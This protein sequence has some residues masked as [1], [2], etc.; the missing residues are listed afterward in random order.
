MRYVPTAN[1]ALD[2][3]KAKGGLK[4]EIV[5]G[6]SINNSLYPVKIRVT[7][8]RDSRFYQLN[9]DYYCTK[10]EFETFLTSKK[11]EVIEARRIAQKKLEEALKILDEIR[12]YFTF[13]EFK[14]IYESSTKSAKDVYSVFEEYIQQKKDDQ[15]FGTANSYTDALKALKKHKKKLYFRDITPSFLKKF[16]QSFENKNTVGIYLRPLRAVYNYAIFKR[17][18]NRDDYPFNKHSYTIPK[19]SS[20]DLAMSID[21]LKPLFQ[22][23]QKHFEEKAD[24]KLFALDMF[25][26][27]YFCGGMNFAD[28]ARLKHSD[29]INNEYFMFFRNK[30]KG[31]TSNSIPTIA[32][33]N[34]VSKAII[35]KHANPFALK[36]DY[37]FPIIQKGISE[38]IIVK[39]IN[40]KRSR[41]NKKLKVIADELNLKGFSTYS[42]RHSFATNMRNENYSYDDIGDMMSHANTTIT[43]GYV[44]K[45]KLDKCKRASEDILRSLQ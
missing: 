7:F 12:D 27:S 36:D 3:R 15:K 30:S 9:K 31:R 11:G 39:R 37:I 43:K 6:E 32:Y 25:I 40:E 33:L 5:N 13:E 23:Q 17:L 16:E 45:S 41:I 19:T 22:Y 21:V 42:A 24:L 18:A 34:E 8:A 14:R 28:I 1:I 26:F 4:K 35:Q 29:I 10:K 38:E 2:T 44:D 20:K